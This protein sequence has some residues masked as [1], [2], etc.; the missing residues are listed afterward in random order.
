[1]AALEVGTAAPELELKQS[2]GRVFRLREALGRGPVMLAFFRTD[3]PICQYSFP[4]LERIRR[5]YGQHESLLLGVSQSELAET[6][7][8]AQQYD[9]GMPMA[10][11]D[12][13]AASR[14]WGL[15]IVPMVFSIGRDGR[16]GRTITG[17]VRD[18]YEALNREYAEANAAEATPLFTDADQ[19]PV[20][21][22]G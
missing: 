14:A 15:S 3:C 18:E 16:I 19:V 1:M 17:F 20:L 6:R 21:R 7:R 22:P 10:L 13:G 12:G 8:F 9:L 11:D 2:D 5:R 4:F